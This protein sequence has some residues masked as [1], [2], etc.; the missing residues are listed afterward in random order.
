MNDNKTHLRRAPHVLLRPA[1]P[2]A[3]GRGARE[4]VDVLLERQALD[5]LQDLLAVVRAER[6]P[7]ALDQRRVPLQR[8]V[9]RLRVAGRCIALTL[10]SHICRCK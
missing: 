8:A 7:H 4:L 6:L 1:L 10:G 2:D 9:E 5:V 3:L